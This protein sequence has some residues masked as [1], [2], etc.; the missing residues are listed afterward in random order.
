MNTNSCPGQPIWPGN[1]APPPAASRAGGYYVDR[2]LRRSARADSFRTSHSPTCWQ[3]KERS[4]TRTIPIS[5]GLRPGAPASS[6]VRLT[7]CDSAAHTTSRFARRPSAS[8]S[9]RSAQA[10]RPAT[11]LARPFAIPSQ[12]QRDFCV[13]SRRPGSGGQHLR[14][15]RPRVQPGV[16]RQSQLARGI[17]GNLY[18]R[19]RGADAIRRAIQHRGRLLRDR[20]RGCGVHDQRADHAGC[21]LPGARCEQ[22]SVSRDHALDRWPDVRGA[23]QQQQYRI[24]VG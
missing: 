20:S 24:V 23:R 17:V 19:R 13:H 22:R 4:D 1:T 21:L 7:G 6:G 12:A 3:S 14:A 15:D 5:A 9:R 10:S 2:G 11:I 16:R 18:R 8:C